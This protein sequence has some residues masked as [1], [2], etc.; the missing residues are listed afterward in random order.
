MSNFF[1]SF[2]VLKAVLL[3]CDAVSCAEVTDSSADRIV[4]CHLKP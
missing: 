4:H 1:A 2:G 3:G